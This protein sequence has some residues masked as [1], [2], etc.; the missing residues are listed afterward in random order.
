MARIRSGASCSSVVVT[1]EVFGFSQ[2]VTLQVVRL[3][4]M[5]L[6][7]SGY[8]D[9]GTNAAVSITQ[10]GLVHCTTSS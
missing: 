2:E 6:T 9:T 8:P 1:A 4:S 7:F 10:H 5:V 3:A